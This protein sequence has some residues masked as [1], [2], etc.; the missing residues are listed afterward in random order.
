[1]NKKN[2]KRLSFFLSLIKFN[3]ELGMFELLKTLELKM[4]VQK[5][6]TGKSFI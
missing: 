2:S 3:Y 6:V 5:N 1:M 4:R